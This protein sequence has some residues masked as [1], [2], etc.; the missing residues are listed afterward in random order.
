M[1]LVAV[2]QAGTARTAATS[3]PAVAT[4]TGSRS[5]TPGTRGATS[6]SDTTTATQYTTTNVS[7]RTPTYAA[8][9]VNGPCDCDRPT[10]PQ[11][12]PPYGQLPENHSRPV[13]SAATTA[14]R[15]HTRPAVEGTTRATQRYA[16]AMATLPSAKNAASSRASANHG[17]GPR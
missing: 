13:Q 3:S 1:P 9:C 11:A 14:G 7:P 12:K 4:R 6:A 15:P 5:V 8:R 17:T 2:G 10:R 16:R